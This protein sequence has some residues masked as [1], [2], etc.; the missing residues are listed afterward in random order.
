MKIKPYLKSIADDIMPEASFGPGVEFL[1]CGAGMNSY[2][3]SEKVLEAAKQ[4]HWPEV[5]WH[6][7][8]NYKELK[9][10]IAEF[11]SAQIDLPAGRI[12]I[13]NGSLEFL[14]RLNQIFLETGARVLGFS[15]PVPGLCA[16]RTGL[17]R[18]I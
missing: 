1:D 13:N 17:R 4:Y 2:G 11:W 9:E 16:R 3:V 7:D 10:K 8:P 12:Q 6:P 15:P 5:W 14:L 18:P